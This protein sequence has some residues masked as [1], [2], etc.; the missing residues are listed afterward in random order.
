MSERYYPAL[1]VGGSK[2]SDDWTPRL[3]RVIVDDNLHFP[4]MFELVFVDPDN[5]GIAGSGISIG[6]EVK[7]TAQNGGGSV[8]LLSGEVTAL[9]G[10][11]DRLGSLVVARG[12]DKAHRLHHGRK[13]KAWLEKTDSDIVTEV[14]GAAGVPTG[15]IDSTDVEHP[16]LVQAGLTDW[17][18]LRSRA[19]A[20]GYDLAMKDG[21]LD[22]RAPVQPSEAPEK[23]TFDSAAERQLVFGLNLHAFRPRVTSAEQVT[24]VEAR[25]WDPAQKDVVTATAQAGTK[26][27]SLGG[28]TPSDLAGKAGAGSYVAVA[29]PHTSTADAQKAADAI[30]ERIGSASVEAE[31]SASG[32]PQLRAGAAVNIAAVGPTFDGKYVLS[33]TRHVFD[34]DG[35][36]THFVVSG[37]QERSLLGLSSG[38]ATNEEVNV[39]DPHHGVVFGRVTDV[40][41][42]KNQGRVKVKLPVLSNEYASDWVACR[43]CR[44]RLQARLPRHPRGGRRGA[45]RLRARR[46]APAYRARIAVQRHGRAEDRRSCSTAVGDGKVKKRVL[47]LAAGPLDRAARRRLRQRHEA[48][49]VRGREDRPLARAT[50]R[51]RSRAPATS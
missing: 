25:G 6:S 29:E 19:R 51:S 18:F 47:H 49:D 10:E 11:Y 26:T 46:S 32:S 45:R 24:S 4:T 35:Y 37:R 21:K 14:A 42:D 7:I 43:L 3:L 12:Y 30:A 33:A 36:V 17:E 44:R 16:Y 23:G 31:G 34:T 40:G 1:E 50:R 8:T 48:G 5:E 39:L 2:L 38:G 27:A 13:T 28:N 22:F 9:E 15:T 20:I 41:D